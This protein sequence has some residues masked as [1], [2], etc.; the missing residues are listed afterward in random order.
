MLVPQENRALFIVY[1][2]MKED[3]DLRGLLEKRRHNLSAHVN[4]LLRV[5]DPPKV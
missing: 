1:T 3:L 2:I 5:M 4:S